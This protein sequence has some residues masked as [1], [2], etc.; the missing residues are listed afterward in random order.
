MSSKFV[1]SKIG[2]N[3]S[4]RIALDSPRSGS[5]YS[6]GQQY[7]SLAGWAYRYDGDP[8]SLVVSHMPG[9]VFRPNRNRADV[10]KLINDAPLE[11]GFRF[12]IDGS[13]EFKIGV[14]CEDGVDWLYLVRSEQVKAVVGRGGHLFLANDANS[15]EEQFAGR[16]LISESELVKWDRYFNF[17]NEW[18][19]KSGNN[20]TFMVA[21]AKEYIYPDLYHVSKGRVTPF[22]QFISRFV[23][24]ANIL[25][26]EVEL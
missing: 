5:D 8:V 9:V 21:P 11:C 25:N 7:I 15:S 22:E 6:K 2:S 4:I 20:Y 23:G 1:V 19:E 13:P 14:A 3:P 16:M 24:K 17:L 18:S 10:V 26:P 12:P